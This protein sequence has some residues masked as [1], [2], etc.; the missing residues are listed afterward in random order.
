MLHSGALDRWPFTQLL[1]HQLG[2]GARG[3]A[4]RERNDQSP[5]IVSG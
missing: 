3:R 4:R 1:L 5:P 2:L